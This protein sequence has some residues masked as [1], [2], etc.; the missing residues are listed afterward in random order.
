M[1]RAKFLLAHAGLKIL[2]EVMIQ[3]EFV[4]CL[5]LQILGVVSELRN[6]CRLCRLSTEP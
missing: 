6:R 1:I 4:L 2:K 5:A 3:K